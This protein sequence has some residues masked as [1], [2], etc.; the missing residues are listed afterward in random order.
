MEKRLPLM[1]WAFF[2]CAVG[3][4]VG[5]VGSARLGGLGRLELIV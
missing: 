4:W 1:G 2:C 3:G 5:L